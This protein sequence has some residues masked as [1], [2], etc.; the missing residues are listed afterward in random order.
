MKTIEKATDLLD[1][2]DQEAL[3]QDKVNEFGSLDLSERESECVSYN[4][5]LATNKWL[6]FKGLFEK[7]EQR[8]KELEGK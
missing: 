6:V 5:S 7:A 3:L 1:M 8:I 2:I 4:F